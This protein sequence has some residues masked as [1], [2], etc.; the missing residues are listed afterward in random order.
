LAFA[1]HT[2]LL[3]ADQNSA[4]L[5]E[6]PDS[7]KDVYE[8][9]D[10]RVLLV[11]DGLTSWSFEPIVQGV[12]ASGDD[13]FFGATA[14]YTPDALDNNNRIYDARIGGGIV[15]PKP[16]PPCPLEVCQGTPKGAPE[17]QA[18]GSTS[19][20]GPGNAEPT[21]NRKC[22]KGKVRRRGRCVA[23]QK[24]PKQ[25]KRANRNRGQGR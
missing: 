9:R 15:F 21:P 12:S 20:T 1:T 18:P 8:W 23:K 5:G 25:H 13:I 4:G 11:T 17:E 2:R 14:Q 19:F 16:P 6:D 22:R 10:G 7:G 3:G 24:R